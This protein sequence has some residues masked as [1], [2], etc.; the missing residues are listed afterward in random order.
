[1]NLKELKDYIVTPTLN[2]INM[3]GD[4]IDMLM[5]CTGMQ[6][7]RYESLV[8]THGPALGFWQVEPRSHNDVD[9][10]LKTQPA[11]RCTIIDICG[12][13]FEAETLVWNL[14]YSLIIARLIYHR[15]KAP[16][17]SYKDIPAMAE[18]YCKY[19]NAGGKEELE[20]VKQLFTETIR[21][22]ES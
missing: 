16:I 4:D 11:L 5:I 3:G 2:S 10:W 8:Q 22:I 18:Y 17:P 15:A 12:N 21:S 7:S 20:H 1:V 9:E 6:E 13:F 19:Y 14:K